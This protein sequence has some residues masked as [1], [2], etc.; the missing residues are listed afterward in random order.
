PFADAAGE[1]EE[2]DDDTPPTG[3]EFDGA[4]NAGD[5]EEPD[6]EPSSPAEV[7]HQSPSDE[8]TLATRADARTLC[9]E[10]MDLL[11][12]GEPARAFD[13]LSAHWAFSQ[14]EMT[15]LQRE[16]ERTRAVVA[17]RYGDE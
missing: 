7:E 14:D 4:D 17:D 6:P 10:A 15:K 2:E 13:R 3:D 11:H 8:P 5:D 16:V 12:A 1:P 9:D